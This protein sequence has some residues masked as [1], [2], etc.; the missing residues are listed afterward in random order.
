MLEWLGKLG[1][2]PDHP[3]ADEKAVKVLISELPVADPF[4]TLEEINYWLDSLAT[5]EGFKPEYR[6]H[7]ALMLEEAA[8]Q[9]LRKLSR[10][11]L[12]AARLPKFQENRLWK[13]LEGFW[14]QVQNA[15]GRALADVAAGARM[16]R[17]TLA[18]A[19]SHAMR[20]SGQAI[21]WMLVRY[22]PV[23][24]AC[25]ER[26]YAWHRLAESQKVADEVVAL[27]TGV[28]GNTS[29]TQEL[30]KTAVLWESAPGSLLPQQLELVERITAHCA[31]LF[32]LRREA[33]DGARW[34]LD[35]AKPGPPQRLPAPAGASLRYVGLGTAREELD[36]LIGCVRAG[37]VPAEVN[38]GGAYPPQQVLEALRHLAAYWSEQPPARRHQRHR[39]VVRLDVVHGYEGVL[40]VAQGIGA[41]SALELDVES[42]VAEDVSTGGF[43]AQ[44]ER[45]APEWLRVG[46]VIGMKPEGVD[47]WGVA[48]VRRLSRDSAGQVRAG[49]ETL[50]NSAAVVLVAPASQTGGHAEAAES[51]PALQLSN[52]AADGETRFLMRGGTY[53]KARPMYMYR[54]GQRYLMLPANLLEQGQDYDI[55][56][57]RVME[58]DT[59]EA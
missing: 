3:L 27:Y 21:K 37:D 55:A 23:D 14:E 53:A 46:S 33:F 49:V 17:A 47:T 13:V 9:H 50:A 43:G 5:A 24:P 28:P 57:Y 2:K 35:L 20:A 22:G 26:L 4:K 36:R 58:Q 8:Q 38:L 11:Y 48:L 45:T 39:V 41:S 52:G 29:P 1:G 6:V 42:W 12:A 40:A 31:G 30:V 25:W 34:V 59:R 56:S 7:I 32:S 51:E 19:L 44:I 54:N 15:H 10:E 16:P 18:A